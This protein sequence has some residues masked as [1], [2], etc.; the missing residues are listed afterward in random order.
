MAA[1][2]PRLTPARADLAAEH[3]RGTVAAPRYAVARACAIASAVAP[4]TATPDAEAPL[5]TTLLRGEAFDVYDSAGGWA[6]GQAADGY[7]G[8]AP[9]ACL[10][11]AGEPA[12]H[13]VTA[14]SAPVYPEPSIKTRPVDALPFLSRL[15]PASAPEAPGFLRLGEGGWVCAQHL[16]PEGVAAPD[17]VSTA[18]RFLGA[19]Y[20]WGGKTAAGIDCSGLVQLA[21]HAAGRACPR[22]SDQ[23]RDAPGAD[24]PPGA[25]RRGDLIFWRGHVG[26]MLDPRRMLHANAF[27]MAV[28]VEPLAD[29]LARIGPAAARRRWRR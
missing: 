14:L 26:V 9:A 28:A 29:A 3:L 11:R 2:D 13:R 12:T 4:L 23:Q 15:R 6:W 10:E 5:S 27:A 21:R 25:E 20:L 8:Y 17:W 1:P 16:G 22:D 18:L 7:V 19:P 24:V